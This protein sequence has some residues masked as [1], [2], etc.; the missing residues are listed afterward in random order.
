MKINTSGE[1]TALA[2]SPPTKRLKAIEAP[3]D[4]MLTAHQVDEFIRKMEK[5]QDFQ[6][7]F[8]VELNRKGEPRL[9][10]DKAAMEL[11]RL[12]RS[13]AATLPIRYRKEI[14]S[15]RVMLFS[16]AAIKHGLEHFSDADLVDTFDN[17]TR[18][19]RR[20]Q[21]LAK[22]I[23]DR[24][25]SPKHQVKL[26]RHTKA[27]G[28]NYRGACLL[29][30][31]LFKKHK[32]GLLVIR[33]DLSYLR[34]TE[35]CVFDRPLTTGEIFAH[36]AAFI[37]ELPDLV[38]DNAL[39]GYLWKT[40]FKPAKGFHHHF[41]IFIDAKKLRQDV[42]IACA[43]GEHWITS[44]TDYRGY[45][46][47]INAE[48]LGRQHEPTTYVGLIRPGDQQRIDSLKAIGVDYVCKPDYLIR[49]VMPEGHRALGKTEIKASL[50][51][52]Q[53]HS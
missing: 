12:L 33:L 10:C 43:L 19:A 4:A 53:W 28:K 50:V 1:A 9:F 34:K 49:W 27:S 31:H 48:Y 47:N 20:L 35:L 40:E 17:V 41:L 45:Y 14:F 6:A 16:K 23:F 42:S 38:Q 52:G 24:C 15:P 11:R 44:I 3:Y 36:R 21:K 2:T 7:S 26:R 22:V 51:T 5:S 8:S 46:K 29:V 39:A 30:D 32:H 37:E 13:G 25:H 18:I